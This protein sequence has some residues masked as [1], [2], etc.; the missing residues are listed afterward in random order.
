MRGRAGV[1]L[2]GCSIRVSDLGRAREFYCSKLGFRPCSMRNGFIELA[3]TVPIFLEQVPPA[4]VPAVDQAR[5]LIMLRVKE[6]AGTAA[7]FRELDIPLVTGNANPL[8]VGVTDC[9][10]DPFGNVHSLV[11]LS[12]PDGE[13]VQEPC[14]YN[15]GLRMPI[16]GVS[17]ARHIY[18]DILGF[19]VASE[20][21]YPPT[22]PLVHADGSPAFVIYDKPAFL[23]DFRSK[24]A[25][26]PAENGTTLVFRTDSA[27][28][29]R[30]DLISRAP[31][32]RVTAV[33]DFSL[34]RRFAI[35]DNAGIASEIWET[36]RKLPSAR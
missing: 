10:L 9:F 22:L 8:H 5:P 12:D 28:A 11:E 23:D 18:T 31:R 6:L 30:E 25:L 32:L 26:Y 17:G 7:R 4:P 27:V 15:V 29:C 33:E 3:S 1:H 13:P 19:M 21:F 35:I 24:A 36:E 34:G 14:V 20:R 16:S 2:L